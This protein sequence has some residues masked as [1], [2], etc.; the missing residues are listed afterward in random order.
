MSLAG[1]RN[2]LSQWF[3]PQPTYTEQHV[4]SQ[5]GKVF[6]VTGGNHGIGFELVKILYAT[7]AKIYMAS[8]SKERAEKAIETITT[9]T[10]APST[11]GT[12]VSLPFDLNDLESVKAAAALFAQRESQLHILWNN[13]GS[14]AYRVEEGA[15]TKQGL[16]PMVGMHCVAAQLF[17]H[18]LLPQLREAAREHEAS[19]GS[20]RVV[21]T[22][23]FMAELTTS[24][25]GIDFDL[26]EKGTP[27]RELNYAVSKFG[28]WL[29]GRE[30]ASRYGFE[31][32]VSVIQNPGNLKAGAYDGVPA[33]SMFFINRLLYETKF[34][35]YTELYAGLSS[36]ISL[37][38]NGAYVIPWGRIRVDEDIPRKDIVEALKPETGG[39]LGY[40][41]KFWDWCEE[42]WK[43]FV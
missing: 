7:G 1:V 11:P 26:L 9:A 15:K 17:T 10:P 41:T 42:Q 37:A 24:Q 40:A 29:L 25:N 3:P 43:P 22:A 4:P 36:D 32:I 6:I 12:I 34:G 2:L 33:F 21:W 19:K 35:A 23:S 18:L 8:R 39:G 16:E 14:G 31:N 5:K 20:V 30:M 27:D 28:N 13:A 38:N